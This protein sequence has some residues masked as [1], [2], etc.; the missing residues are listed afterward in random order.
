[1][2]C[3]A[4]HFTSSIRQASFQHWMVHA[5]PPQLE[6]LHASLPLHTSTVCGAVLSTRRH[7][8]SPVH[9]ILQLVAVPQVTGPQTS[10]PTQATWQGI[11]AGHV[12]PAEHD[13]AP[14]HAIT[15]VAP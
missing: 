10:F 15:Q 7:A 8:F 1:V 5:S 11:P 3:F 4:Q 2:H 12:T 6:A 9:S 14:G 13:G